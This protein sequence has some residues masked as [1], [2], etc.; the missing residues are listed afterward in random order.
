MTFQDHDTK[1][2]LRDMITSELHYN[3]QVDSFIFICIT[4]YKAICISQF[5]LLAQ[6]G[7][8]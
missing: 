5:P 3:K 8:T 6:S 2:K 7:H 1:G 4:T